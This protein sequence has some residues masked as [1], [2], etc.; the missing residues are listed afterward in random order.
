VFYLC[1]EMMGHDYLDV[2]VYV[3]CQVILE[4]EVRPEWMVIYVY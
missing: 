3:M 1:C 4:P 2:D